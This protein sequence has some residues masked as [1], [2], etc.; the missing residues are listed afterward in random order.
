MNKQPR[1]WGRLPGRA[2]LRE[3]GVFRKIFSQA[4]NIISLWES[5]ADGNI[6]AG[7]FGNGVFI[8]N[9]AGKVL[10]HLTER[11]GLANGTVFSIGGT[12]RQVWLAT[13]GG[14]AGQRCASSIVGPGLSQ[15]SGT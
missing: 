5:P 1:V 13:L 14:G 7:T 8:V 6:R 15:A 4:E 2:F 11:S 3:N 9:R 12:A 10:Q